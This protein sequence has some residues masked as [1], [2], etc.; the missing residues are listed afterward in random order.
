MFF[1]LKYYLKLLCLVGGICFCPQMALAKNVKSVAELPLE[2]RNPVP[3][4]QEL[5]FDWRQLETLIDEK[6]MLLV[7][8]LS[9]Y[10]L[11]GKKGRLVEFNS[12]RAVTAFAVIDA[13]LG[14]VK[15]VVS[16]YERYV[17]F[18]PRTTASN[19]IQ[20]SGRHTIVAYVLN[21]KIPLIDIDIKYLLQHTEEE[22][23]DLS[24][25][26]LEGDMKGGASRWE[27]V[28]LENNKTL[29]MYTNWN[30]VESVGLV[31]KTVVKAQPEMKLTSPVLSAALA[32]E[33][34]QEYF[35]DSS[36]PI[37]KAK[38]ISESNAA[39]KPTATVNKTDSIILGSVSE[40]R[41]PSY[42]QENIPLLRTLTRVGIVLF[43]H[44]AQTV[45]IENEI[46]ELMFVTVLGGVNGGLDEVK[47]LSTE[48]MRYPEYFRQVARVR[49]I[50]AE[51]GKEVDWYYRFGFGII[52]IPLR[53]SLAYRWQNDNQ[54]LFD[55][56]AGDIDYIVGG[57]EWVAINEVETLS[58]YT[59]AIALKESP[60]WVMTMVKQ[61][62]KLAMIGGVSFGIMV[63]ENQLPWI[64]AMIQ[65]VEYRPTWKREKKRR[66]SRP[67]RRR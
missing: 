47:N 3:R 48:F 9:R 44:P 61:M 21:F 40:P 20:Q 29:L 26:M 23:G 38:I 1:E 5:G 42:Q 67:S 32:V 11:P 37:P 22:N 41:V 46:T 56:V 64:E 19:I 45:R 2:W 30:D 4:M 31:F 51:Q 35:M 36:K 34:V 54:L 62:P 28:A 49:E 7:H 17:E 63:M 52:S 13:P 65:G 15:K 6:M 39:P 24:V 18:M 59:S 60:S 14:E 8:P 53:Y 12:A 66:S 58:F 16:G 55:R 33:A 10:E 50:E 57:L 43:I 25:L 27:F